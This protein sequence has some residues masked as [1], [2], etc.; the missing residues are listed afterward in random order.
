MPKAEK[1]Y[2]VQQIAKEIAQSGGIPL[3][4][5]RDFEETLLRDV[6]YAVD[7]Y[8]MGVAQVVAGFVV[9]NSPRVEA[10]TAA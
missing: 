2:L 5:Q 4:H 10:R 6:Q 1:Q 8:R 7:R 9:G 3:E